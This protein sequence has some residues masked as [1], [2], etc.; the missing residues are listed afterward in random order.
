MF[1]RQSI[2][3]ICALIVGL[4]SSLAAAQG[5]CQAACNALIVNDLYFVPCGVDPSDP[6]LYGYYADWC[7]CGGPLYVTMTFTGTNGAGL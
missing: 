7:D 2:G 5:A 4:L 6:S 1:A 3:R